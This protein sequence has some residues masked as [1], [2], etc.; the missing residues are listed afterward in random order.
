MAASGLREIG[1]RYFLLLP[2][3]AGLPAASKALAPSSARRAIRRLRH[4][5]SYF[6]GASRRLCTTATSSL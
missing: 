3:E 6:F 4:G 2:W 1:A 5:L